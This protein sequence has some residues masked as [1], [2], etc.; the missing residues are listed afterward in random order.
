MSNPAPESVIAEIRA[1]MGRQDINGN[2]LAERLG[3]S[4]MWV[5]RRLSGVTPLR[6]ADLIRIADALGVPITQFLPAPASAGHVQ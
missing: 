5:S 1:E 4:E 6:V 3:T 2:Q